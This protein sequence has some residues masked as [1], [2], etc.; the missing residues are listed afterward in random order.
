MQNRRTSAEKPANGVFREA[1][2]RGAK[3]VNVLLVT[4]P[5]L[6]CWLAY[7]AP[8][9]AVAVSPLRSACVVALF[10]LLFCFFG[11]T[12]DAFLLSVRRPGELL[13]SQ[14][15]SI[16]MTDAF[17]FIV[18]WLMNGG[19]PNLLPALLALSGQLLL[20]AVWC[21]L[22]HAWHKSRFAGQKT[23]VI[24]D[25]KS[26]ADELLD[27]EGL[28][29]MFSVQV[30][31]T[32]E[33]C[34]KK[35]MR[36]LEGMDAAILCGI[37]SHERNRIL[38][39]C[40]AHGI[41]A[42]VAPRIGDLLMSGARRTHLCHR[43]LLRV[44]SYSPS[45]EFLFFKRLFDVT[46][47]A[48]AIL[49]TS[50]LMLGVAIAIRAQDGGPVLYRQ[51][52][53]T[54]GGRPFS[55]LKFRSMRTDA[56]KDGVA[57]LCSGENDDRITPVG[58]FIRACRLDELPQLFNILGGSMSVVGPRPERPEI[59]RQYERQIPEFSLRLQAKAGLTGY[60]QVY[61]KYNTD[62]YDKLQMDL[63][64]MAKPSLLEDLKIIFA[65]VKI[66]FVSESTEGIQAGQTTAMHEEVSQDASDGGEKHDRNIA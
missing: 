3:A 64:Y 15:L 9:V 60:A 37:H 11:R 22:A 48:A 13:V 31:C 53:L 18:L 34:L 65:T 43:P 21:R 29:G 57:R 25:H 4:L 1:C 6:G 55:I 14:L 30:Q 44:E 40:V 36:P 63:M 23:A 45:P 49:L 50:P 2:L 27:R 28:G 24:Y 47:S 41:C 46:A 59:A 16:L 42:Y 5:F 52:R 61:G 35:E 12:Y 10:V 66:L 56:E 20:S 19:F 54:R 38:K 32:A 62:P 17:L 26:S 39:Y 7:Y 51:T 58:R 33:E 8:R